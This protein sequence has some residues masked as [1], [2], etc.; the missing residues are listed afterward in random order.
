MCNRNGRMSVEPDRSGTTTGYLVGLSVAISLCIGLVQSSIAVP[1]TATVTD[2][3]SQ[4][5]EN[6][7]SLIKQLDNAVLQANP[8]RR[9]FESVTAYE[10][11][12]RA[13]TVRLNRLLERT[14]RLSSAPDGVKLD[15]ENSSITVVLELP[16]Q[17]HRERGGSKKTTQLSIVV[18][19]EPVDARVISSFPKEVLVHLD[20]RLSS[21]KAIL[22]K[23][24]RIVY[25]NKEIYRE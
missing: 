9:D 16:I 22:L 4:K 7:N 10:Q 24:L 25:R 6:L 23:G 18:P 12:Q 3:G 17:V 15:W 5:P 11:R 1:I 8:T 14:F 21:T 13:N 19:V 20:F 2:L